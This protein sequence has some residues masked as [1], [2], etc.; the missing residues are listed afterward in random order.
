M[1]KLLA[2]TWRMSKGRDSMLAG[3]PREGV[4]NCADF[5]LAEARTDV[6]CRDWLR[7]FRIGASVHRKTSKNK[8]DSKLS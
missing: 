6:I 5:S 4:Q 1:F 7:Y 8:R 3:M 2:M